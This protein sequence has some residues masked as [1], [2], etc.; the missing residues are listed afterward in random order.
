MRVC[1]VCDNSLIT[2]EIKKVSYNYED[3]FITMIDSD[4]EEIKIKE[5]DISIAESIIHRLTIDGFTIMPS[6]KNANKKET[7]FI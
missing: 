6:Y 2:K 1:Y 4:N 7:S 3:N 5:Y